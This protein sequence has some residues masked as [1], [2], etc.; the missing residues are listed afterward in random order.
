MAKK[1][2]GLSET[3]F[4]GID[5]YGKKQERQAEPAGRLVYLPLAVIRPDPDQPRRL[6]P[7]N[8]QAKLEEQKAYDPLAVMHSWLAQAPPEDARLKD[9]RKLADSIARH[10]LINPITVRL[11]ATP[12]PD[13][14]QYLIVTGARR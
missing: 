14:T 10:G 11:L 1:R 12:L 7:G 9:L 4:S 13:G 3:L 5:P 2:T 8:L 6:L